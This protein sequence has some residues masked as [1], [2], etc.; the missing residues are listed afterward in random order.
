VPALS[1]IAPTLPITTSFISTGEF[2]SSVPT[3]SSST[4]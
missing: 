1:F 4:W 2:D 3:L